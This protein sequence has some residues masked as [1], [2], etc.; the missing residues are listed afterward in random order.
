MAALADLSMLSPPPRNIKVATPKEA[1][2][3]LAT[4]PT[5]AAQR[6]VNVGCGAAELLEAQGLVSEGVEL[7][8]ATLIEAARVYAA[9]HSK[10]K[11][12]HMKGAEPTAFA[13]GR[14]PL[15]MVRST[16]G[17]SLGF[18]LPPSSVCSSTPFGP[19]HTQSPGSVERNDS[20]STA[21]PPGETLRGTYVAGR[22]SLECRQIPRLATVPAAIIISGTSVVRHL[23]AP[24]FTLYQLNVPLVGTRNEHVAF[25]RYSDFVDLDKLLTRQVDGGLGWCF[26]PREIPPLPP[27]TFF[28][29]DATAPQTIAERCGCILPRTLFDRLHSRGTPADAREP[30]EQLTPAIRPPFTLTIVC[31]PSTLRWNLLQQY[32][33]VVMERVADKPEAWEIFRAWLLRS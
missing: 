14:S 18:P 20:H 22:P 33:D 12:Q 3:P 13:M 7:K 10:S 27:K 15:A 31:R 6:I 21:S 19:L 23:E 28:W 2:S 17:A 8:S 5:E 24:H 29:Q 16:N 11:Q 9:A 1:R 30:S 26:A 4:P 25:R 32:L